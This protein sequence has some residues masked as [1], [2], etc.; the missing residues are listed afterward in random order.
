MR[1]LIIDDEPRIGLTLRLLLEEHEV[2]V[3]TSGSEAREELEGGAFDAVLCDLALDDTSGAELTR[4][5]RE[6]RPEL[7]ERI[8]LMTGGA[9][10]A[11]DRALVRS[12][13][14]ER[15]LDKPFTAAQ[16][17][18]ALESLTAR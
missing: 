7:A 4:W 17:R 1:L 18:A 2:T 15:R 13:P 10:T 11:D 9:I 6:H 12:L 5:I 8:V 14:P 3:A 16:V